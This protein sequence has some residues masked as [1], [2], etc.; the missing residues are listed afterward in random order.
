[1][2][3]NIYIGSLYKQVQMC[4]KAKL[5]KKAIKFYPWIYKIHAF[6]YILENYLKVHI[7]AYVC[8]HMRTR[9]HIHNA[10][11]LVTTSP[12]KI[13]DKDKCYENVVTEQF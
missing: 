4:Y 3:Q 11:F 7:H 8:V 10:F 13:L 9:A 5:E 2:F 6:T 1:M 12:Y